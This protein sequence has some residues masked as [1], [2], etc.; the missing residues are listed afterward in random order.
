M[1]TLATTTALAL[2]AVLTVAAAGPATAASPQPLLLN[3]PVAPPVYSLPKFGFNSY[4]ISG[5]GEQVTYVRWG[6]IA[7]QMGLQPSCHAVA[8]IGDKI[9]STISGFGGTR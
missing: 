2:A 3:P 5:I 7:W 4:N 6:G 9:A 8:Q 1:K